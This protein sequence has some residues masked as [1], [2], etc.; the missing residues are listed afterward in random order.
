MTQDIRMSL[1]IGLVGTVLTF[2]AVVPPW[3]FFNKNPE[4]WLPS[5]KATSGISINVDGQQVG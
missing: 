3:P 2:V 5:R 4:G 1:Y